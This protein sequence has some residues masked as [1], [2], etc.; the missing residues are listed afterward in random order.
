MRQI[1]VMLK[2]KKITFN[3]FLFLLQLDLFFC[4][5]LIIAVTLK[6]LLNRFQT[7]RMNATG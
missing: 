2:I 7:F 4:T 3:F 6:R 1:A 5:V